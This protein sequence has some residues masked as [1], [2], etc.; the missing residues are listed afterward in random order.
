MLLIQAYRESDSLVEWLRRL[1]GVLADVEEWREVGATGN[2][3][4]ENSW[5]NADSTTAAF[6]RDPYHVVRLKGHIDTGSSGTT[7]FTLPTDYRPTQEQV[8]ELHTATGS[9]A[10]LTIGTDGT[11]VPSYSGG[12]S[13]VSLD[14]VTLRV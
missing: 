7:A 1:V 3:A 6:Y 12:G 4:F 13:E 14:G 10:A 2:P 11:V 9:H 8:L 5:D